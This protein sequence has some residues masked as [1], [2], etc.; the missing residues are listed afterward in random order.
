MLGWQPIGGVSPVPLTADLLLSFLCCFRSPL[1]LDLDLWPASSCSSGLDFIASVYLHLLLHPLL[2]WCRL[3]ALG[4]PLLVS[5]GIC[6]G[7]TEVAELRVL[8]RELQLQLERLTV[9]VRRLEAERTSEDSRRSE[10]ERLV[11]PEAAP[12]ERWDL[13]STPPRTTRGD[14]RSPS[15]TPS[16]GYNSLAI[17]IPDCPDF[18]LRIAASLRGS[19]TENRSRGIR[20]WEIGYWARFVLQGRIARPRP[21]VPAPSNLSNTIYVVLRAPGWNTPLVCN[22]GCDYRHILGSFNEE[23]LSHGFPSLAEAKIYCHGAGVEF[24]QN[25][26]QWSN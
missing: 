3:L 23:T 11:E 10:A 16:G 5:K 18:C 14:Y 9:S 13:V 21:S 6:M 26:Y 25:R 19:N 1:A 2:A 12:S 15:G 22:R 20:A 24:P 8:V 7:D 4:L 17:E